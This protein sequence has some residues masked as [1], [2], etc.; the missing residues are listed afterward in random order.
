MVGSPG[1]LQAF[2]LG[3]LLTTKETQLTQL[4]QE[5]SRLKIESFEMETNRMI[6]IREI[7]RVLGYT[8]ADEMIFDFNGPNS[9]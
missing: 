1:A 3:K 8:A 6:Q 7:R 5:L 9:F 2:R 4:K